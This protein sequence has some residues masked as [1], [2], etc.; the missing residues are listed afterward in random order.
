VLLSIESLITNSLLPGCSFCKLIFGDDKNNFYYF[1]F[2]SDRFIV[3]SVD[4]D[5]WGKIDNTSKSEN[6]NSSEDLDNN[7][8][9]SY[10]FFNTKKLPMKY[11]RLEREIN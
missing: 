5:I 11:D 8:L 6:S 7:I 9:V 4:S 1:S 3:K 10:D 2:D